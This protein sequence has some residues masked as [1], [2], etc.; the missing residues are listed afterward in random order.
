MACHATSRKP[1]WI[2]GST[3]MRGVSTTKTEAT[4]GEDVE[5]Y[6][7]M[8]VLW[9]TLCNF[10]LVGGWATPLKN[11][12]VN[13]DDEIPNIWENK[14]CS[15]P[16]TSKGKLKVHRYVTFCGTGNS[17]VL[18]NSGCTK[19]SLLAT[20]GSPGISPQ[21]CARNIQNTDKKA[22]ALTILTV[23]YS[24][25][26]VGVMNMAPTTWTSHRTNLVHSN[27]QPD[28]EGLNRCW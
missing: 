19:Y 28:P 12:N 8:S 24:T 11:M 9:T 4:C 7:K 14:K 23:N 27:R 15:K 2:T 6:G 5:R 10:K 16:P 25:F 13:W 26:P 21:K 3:R 20:C 18:G 22:N 1:A 17:K